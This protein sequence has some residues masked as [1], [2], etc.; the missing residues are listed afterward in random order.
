M[1]DR[2]ARLL[3]WGYAA[4]LAAELAVI[5]AGA[6]WARW[7]TKPSLML[8]LLGLVASAA[9]L[10]GP[11]AAVL[12][13]GLVLAL[14]ADIA[15]LVEGTVAFLV[16]VGVFACMQVCYLVLFTRLGAWAGLRR[17]MAVP[18]V[19]FGLWLT[20]AV[21]LW[22]RLGSLA[23]PIAAY[24]LLL[25]SMGALAAGIGLRVGLGGAL[26][27]LS[28]L[29]IGIGVAGAEFPLSGQAVMAAYAAAQ[30]LIVTGVLVRLR[31]RP[32]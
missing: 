20:A 27:V 13:L 3:L 11:D 29:L 23:A 25:V 16:G 2:G 5:S 32:D 19:Y 12:T 22:P 30:V 6:D 24:S 21:V 10:R 4:A 18:V 7:I 9:R 8:L 31:A 28:D 1:G 17:H 15:L 26:F 14:A